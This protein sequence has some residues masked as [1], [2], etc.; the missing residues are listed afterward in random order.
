MKILEYEDT[1]LTGEY[2]WKVFQKDFRNFSEEDFI[3]CSPAYVQKLQVHLRIY[4]VWV[5]K[6][7]RITTDK[8]PFNTLQEQDP[9]SWPDE[10]VSIA[11]PTIPLPKTGQTPGFTQQTQGQAWQPEFG[12][13]QERQSGFG[14]G[15]V[16]TNLA[17][18]YEEEYKYSGVNDNFDFKL[19]IFH[20]LCARADVPEIA[21][22]K[23]YPTM[24]RGSALDHYYTNLNNNPQVVPFDQICNATRKYF[25]GPEYRRGMVAKWNSTTLKG[26]MEQ[27]E[28][29]GRKASECFELLIKEWRHL[30]HGLEPDLRSE[31][32]L[33]HRMISACQTLPA[34]RYACYRPSDT[35]AGLIGDLRSS[36]ETYEKS[37]AESTNTFFTDRRYHRQAPRS[38]SLRSTPF[39]RRPDKRP[40]KKRCFVCHKEGCWS[41]KH[42][43]EVREESQ[44]KFKDKFNRNYDKR[45]R[46]YVADYE[47]TENLQESNSESESLDD[48][49]ET[50]VARSDSP[51]MSSTG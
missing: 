34:C 30:Q 48:T 26:T 5:Q 31:K 22:A 45:I 23:A 25:E 28:I 17:K 37:T 1:K 24:L 36:I 44:R 49:L 41:S 35:L 12:F 4:G 6:D 46:Q 16:L 29:L 15:K 18:M 14:F 11:T 2:L 38:P 27:E 47:G 8:Y 40:D 10:P 50:L 42:S 33:Y 20:D 32:T 19:V 3:K 13:G 43:K 39:R 51:P 21:K 7:T 9:A